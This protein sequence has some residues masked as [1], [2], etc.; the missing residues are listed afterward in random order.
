MRGLLFA[1]LALL[2]APATAGVH[3]R[4]ATLS[5]DGGVTLVLHTDHGGVL[6]PRTARGQYGFQNP[7]V[8]PDGRTVGWLELVPVQGMDGPISGDLVLFRNGRVVRQFSPDGVVI[9]K[10]A[11]AD[12]DKAV[13]YV[14]GSLHVPTGFDYELR[15]IADG[16]LLD[17]FS[18]G[19]STTGI[20]PKVQLGPWVNHGKVPAWVW[21]IAED[22]PVRPGGPR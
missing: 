2:A 22:C 12:G 1:A 5:A 14:T 21:P 4:G 7:H 16:R 18:C 9:W 17:R 19:R 11:F 13:A 6:A 15:G 8:S 3:Y 10:W 20:P